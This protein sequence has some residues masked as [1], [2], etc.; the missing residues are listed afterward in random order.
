MPNAYTILKA[1][2]FNQ[3]ISAFLKANGVNPNFSNEG[4]TLFWDFYIQNVEGWISLFIIDGKVHVS[5]YFTIGAINSF[6]RRHLLKYLERNS[7]Q[8]D[9]YYYSTLSDKFLILG[10]IN[11][12]NQISL[13]S[14]ETQL[15]SLLTTAIIESRNFDAYSTAS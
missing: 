5:S 13:N 2:S 8:S 6:N 1:H 4:S 15:N 9:G 11:Q 10:L 7:T 3:A 12:T 14:F